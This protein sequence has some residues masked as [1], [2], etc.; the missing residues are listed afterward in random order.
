VGLVVAAIL[1]RHMT[2]A[3]YGTVALA[4]AAALMA[5]VVAGLGLEQAMSRLYFI[6]REQ[7]A[8][9]SRLVSSVLLAAMG[10]SVGCFPLFL[11][12]GPSLQKSFGFPTVAFYPFLAIALATALLQKL[13]GVFLRLFQAERN[14]MAV[15]RTTV[16]TNVIYVV[17]ALS[18]VVA[19]GYGA[20]GLLVSRLVS[21]VIVVG[22]LSIV[23]L[24]WIR[25]GFSGTSFQRAVAFSVPLLPYQ[26]TL[27]LM[28]TA[29]RFVIDYFLGPDRVGVYVLGSAVG[30]GAMLVL[31]N[32]AISA[33]NPAFYSSAS[34]PDGLARIARET[35]RILALLAVLGI[36][37]LA[38][39]VDFVRFVFDARYAES[40]LLAAWFIVSMFFWSAFTFFNLALLEKGWTWVSSAI[41][42]ASGVLN[43][44]LNI[45]LVPRYGVI[46]AAFATAVS[47][48]FQAV[49]GLVVAQRAKRI[50]FRYGDLLAS[51]A[52]ITA[53]LA[54]THVSLPAPARLAATLASAAA[55]TAF[56]NWKLDLAPSL[57]SLRE[58]FTRQ[59]K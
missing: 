30:G 35:P 56:L 43:L 23:S 37:G 20:V 42:V 7:T 8:E 44:G 39:C 14:P 5:A 27:L 25:F 2:R 50:P 16:A 54:V 57:L 53:V 48:L 40:G 52:S 55:V 11:W 13:V 38:I 24:R 15:V 31:A 34:S 19:L 1:T 21:A 26:A 29:D 32:A 36:A 51:A 33:W 45:W 22:T 18:L 9:H 10:L 3:D 12:F 46:A 28:Q 41:T 17:G 4:E 59:L 6:H 47:F 49:F 58:H